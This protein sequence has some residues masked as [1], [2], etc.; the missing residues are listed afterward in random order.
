LYVAAAVAVFAA[1]AVNAPAPLRYGLGD[2]AVVAFMPCLWMIVKG[3]NSSNPR[4]RLVRLAVGF[5]LVVALTGSI[6]WI[7]FEKPW[8][9]AVAL[10]VTVIKDDPINATILLDLGVDPTREHSIFDALNA[11][12]MVDSPQMV[13]LLIRHGANMN[14]LAVGCLTPLM[15]AA[16]NR[17]TD[18]TKLLLAAG[19]R[20]NQS[21]PKGTTALMTALVDDNPDELRLLISHGADIDAQTRV[22]TTALMAAA[23]QGYLDCVRILVEQGADVNERSMRGRTALDFAGRHHHG[24]IA[25]YLRAHGGIA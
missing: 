19:A 11:A 10:C 12:V 23:R 21:D 13:K 6:A 25:A 4:S 14:S 20:V 3:D 16:G 9:P 15:A 22:G 5:C 18:C 17:R 2:L 1:D 8:V 7:H 24:D